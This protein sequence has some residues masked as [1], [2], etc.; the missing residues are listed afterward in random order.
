MTPSRE[1]LRIEYEGA[2]YRVMNRGDHM[3]A[4]ALRLRQEGTMTLSWI[5][6]RLRTATRTHLSHL[7]YW[8]GGQRRKSGS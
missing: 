4:I 5:P 3:V 8:Q 2:I 6:E 1:K 7:L